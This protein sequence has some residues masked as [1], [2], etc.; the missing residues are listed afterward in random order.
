M[1]K[2]PTRDQLAR[3]LPTQELIRAFEQLFDLADGDS[4]DITALQL[5]VNTLAA[6][7]LEAEE[8]IAA[9]EIDALAESAQSHAVAAA[10]GELAKSVDGLALRP[11]I[12]PAKRKRY[13]AFHDLTTQ[14]ATLVNTVYPV[15]I[16][17]TDITRGV[18]V[19][20]TS[21]SFTADISG[22]TM[23]V[24]AVSAGELDIGQ[25]V[26]GTGV[27]AGTRII[28]FLSGSGNTGTYTVDVSQVVASTN[29]TATKTSRVVVD[30]EGI[31]DFQFSLQLDKATGGVGIIDIWARVNGVDVP[32]SASRIRIQG[33]DAETVPT[34]NFMFD[35]NTGDWFELVYA[36]DN[37]DVQ[38]QTY[39]ASSPIPAIPS[40]LL[41]VT[42]GI[43]D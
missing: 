26:S 18:I 12:V 32:N 17:G 33:N 19:Q 11:A 25:V 42:N 37:I 35:M 7:V 8:A 27:T 41:T 24:T 22:T 38:I 1:P 14:Q 3:F 15:N 30:T 6:R 39:A 20:T 40:V 23:T 31:Y 13:G 34:W 21:A 10:M 9:G 4:G 29:M 36:V 43:G 28:A 2:K 16:G 5:A